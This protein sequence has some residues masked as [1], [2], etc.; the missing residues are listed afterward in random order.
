MNVRTSIA[1]VVFGGCAALILGWS[2]AAMA[3][4]SL[5]VTPGTFNGLFRN[6]SNLQHETSG[7]IS[8]KVTAKGA[9]SGYA[10]LG[11]NRHAFSGRWPTNGSLPSLQVVRRGASAL[12]LNLTNTD[13]DTLEG[14]LSDGTWSSAL[15]AG[16]QVWHKT[17]RPASPHAGTYTAGI[18]QSAQPNH[19]DGFGYGTITVDLAGAVTLVGALGDGTKAVQKTALLANGS[20][21]FY[22]PA[23]GRKGSISAWISLSNSMPTDGNVFWSKASD[24][25]SRRYPAGFTLTAPMHAAPYVPP[26]MFQRI[27]NISHGYVA[28]TGGPLASPVVNELSLS[29]DN[30]VTNLGLNPMTMKINLRTG[31]VKGSLKVGSLV[32]K[33]AGVFMQSVDL[34]AGHFLGTT[35][36]GAM[37]IAGDA[38]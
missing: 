30:K 21:P 26:A 31:L 15:L 35:N 19:P 4:P 33:F 28:L 36:T 23:Y 25:A 11:G 34:G 24:P 6:I 3:Q 13:L 37:I 10:I 22:V 18:D 20:W 17:E 29:L 5:P 2:S 32:N 27:I 12:T 1:P 8:A 38:Q 16:R 14:T 7:F 9:L